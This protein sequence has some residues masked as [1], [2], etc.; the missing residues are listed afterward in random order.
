MPRHVNNSSKI[1]SKMQCKK[2]WYIP[3]VV[4]VDRKCVKTKT[5]TFKCH[6]L[7]LS[8]VSTT[9]SS[10]SDQS[11]TAT[12]RIAAPQAA[13]GKALIPAA[14]A[15]SA[16]V[17]MAGA[18]VGEV[19]VAVATGSVISPVSYVDEPVSVGM[20]ASVLGATAEVGAEKRVGMGT[21]LMGSR[22]VS[23]GRT[24]AADWGGGEEG[25][26]VMTESWHWVLMTMLQ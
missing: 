4:N 26:D 17:V 1:S 8:A 19:S 10:I 18:P 20:V 15:V 21:D 14:A 24:D 3:F 7:P 22:V 16:V 25:A 12:A 11:K 6:S 23:T 2:P 13:P 5:K 9:A